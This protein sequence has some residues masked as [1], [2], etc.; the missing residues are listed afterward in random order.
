MVEGWGSRRAEA[1]WLSLGNL[2][3]GRDV[4]GCGELCKGRLLDRNRT[5]RG[6]VKVTKRLEGVLHLAQSPKES[7]DNRSIH[8][9]PFLT[10]SMSVAVK[11]RVERR[12]QE[13]DSSHTASSVAKS[14]KGSSHSVCLDWLS[15]A[16]MSFVLLSQCAQANPEPSQ[17]LLSA[18]VY[19]KRGRKMTKDKK[20]MKGRAC[21]VKRRGF[22]E[23]LRSPSTLRNE[24]RV[25][26][27][28]KGE[29]EG[30]GSASS[31]IG[32]GVLYFHIRPSRSALLGKNTAFQD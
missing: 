7:G 22:A 9:D 24:R 27:H 17:A 13:A 6:R 3:G 2:L 28:K 31:R 26:S 23:P 10:N 30:Q 4:A 11:I 21:D 16:E 5:E 29:G 18:E 8:Y 14:A 32:R 1:R 25:R 12:W 19:L 15:G 20:Y